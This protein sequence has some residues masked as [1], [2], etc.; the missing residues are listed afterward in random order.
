MM[1]FT[2]LPALA[3]GEDYNTSQ[4]INAEFKTEFNANEASKGQVVQFVSTEDYKID[5]VVIPAGTIFSGEVKHFKKGRWAYRRAKAVI[6]INKMILPDGKEYK[7]KASTKRHVLKGSAM[8][9]I[10]KGI[11]SFP[12]AIIVGVTGAVVI[13][14]ESVSI[15]GLIVVGPTS[16]AFGRTMGQLTHG[17][18]YKKHVGDDIK[19]KIKSVKND[20]I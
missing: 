15:V 14:L 3:E 6:K 2:Y 4:V 11:V 12:V 17:I 9:N 8:G 5:D 13:V 16:Y 7:I 20:S 1:N 10:G 19:L 18:N